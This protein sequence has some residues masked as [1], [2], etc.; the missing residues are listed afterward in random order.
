MCGITGYLTS[1]PEAADELRSAV[2]RM[3][4]AIALRG[5]DDAGNWSDEAAGIVLGH[6]RLAIVDTSPL[7][8]Q[9]MVSPC[10]R[11]WMIFNGEIYNHLELRRRLGE[12]P[13]RGHSDTETVLACFSR[14]G[15]VAT[16]S[17]LVGM[18]AIA[19]WDR[20]L[21]QLTL[22]RDR[23]GEK[24]LYYGALPSGDFVFGSEL[25]ALRAHP[26][27]HGRVDRNALALFM[28]HNCIPAPW[29][30]YEGIRKLRP[31]HWLT[32]SREGRSTEGCYW[33]L[34]SVATRASDE[35]ARPRSDAEAVD[36]LEAVLSRAVRG[37]MVA[38]VPLGA[39]LSGGVDSSAIVALM[40]QQGTRQVR[41]FS[42]GFEDAGFDEAVHA[43]AVARHLGTRHTELYV[44]VQ[45]ALSVVGRL[46]ALYDEP[47]AD[48][49]QIPTY[50]V[51]A[52]ARRDVTVALSGDGGDELFAGYTRYRIANDLWS[53][54]AALPLPLRRGAARAIQAL[55]P[56]AWDAAA[57]WPLALLP[58][59]RR[60]ANVGDK[61]H[62]FAASVL[63]ATSPA[64]MYRALVSHWSDPPSVLLGAVEP[65]SLLED[66]RVQG[67]LADPVERM[68]L[69]DQLTYLPD[70]ILVKVD[71]AAMGVSLETRVPLLDHR[72][73][74]FAWSVPMHQKIR[75]G[76]SKWLLRQVL[77]R[78]VPKA[79][80][81]RPKQGFAVPLAQ[82]LRGP[83]RDWAQALL[84]PS[85]LRTEGF[86]DAAQITLKWNEHLSGIR[87]WQYLLWDVLMF[88]AWLE[89]VERP[90]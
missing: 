65:A 82:W 16:L 13:W 14:F 43:K 80:I 2:A 9:P 38:D 77:Y 62:K 64:S 89:A 83:L 49:S 36:E 68:S 48:S 74:E 58:K 22:A 18:F 63:P 37:Q 78:H 4:D 21:Q 54:L 45:D 19:V 20:E 47:F 51:S 50:L 61:L 24:P 7:G 85:R 46:P 53:R 52:M 40:C 1:R 25:K 31:G 23:L 5:P 90:A 42:I 26:R 69:T 15:V 6:R 70:D 84:E 30:V 71:R 29:S 35:R 75:N 10:G 33:D 8:H 56:A 44:S 60:L 12:L 88:Q 34:V 28:R 86:F 66:Q 55:P 73:V 79:L 72:V 3:C 39:F 11:Y 41:T 57:R 27:W 87:N 59:R 32:M 17:E 76:Q 81:E 67:A